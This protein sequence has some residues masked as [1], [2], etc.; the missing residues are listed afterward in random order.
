MTKNM[1]VRRVLRF[2]VQ[3]FPYFILFS[4]QFQ[5]PIMNG[6][7]KEFVYLLIRYLVIPRLSCTDAYK[8]IV[9]IS[10][11]VDFRIGSKKAINHQI[12][13]VDINVE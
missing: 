7:K 2:R 1:K 5:T 3:G 10:G 6:F 4:F 13:G 12:K 11:I 8:E 9:G